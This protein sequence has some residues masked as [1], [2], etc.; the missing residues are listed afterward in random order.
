MLAAEFS[1]NQPYCD[2]YMDLDAFISHIKYHQKNPPA[3]AVLIGVIKQMFGKD[4]EN[5]DEEY[6][7]NPDIFTTE[8]K[9]KLKDMT[10]DEKFKYLSTLPLTSG[11]ARNKGKSLEHFMDDFNAVGG[12]SK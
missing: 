3:G 6:A 4:D 11:Q 12:V 1:Y 8:V 10:M 9:D 2:L 7:G 5:K